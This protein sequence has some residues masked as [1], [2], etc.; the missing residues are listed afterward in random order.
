MKQVS[1]LDQIQ[2]FNILI[3]DDDEDTCNLL[4]A[5]FKTRGYVSKYVTS[6]EEAIAYVAEHDPDVVVLD[7]MM[8]NMNG[9]ETFTGIRAYSD[10][11]VLFLTAVATIDCAAHA[12]S[13]GGSDFM[14]KPF[15]HL[16]LFARIDILLKAAQ[17]KHAK[18]HKPLAHNLINRDIA[19]TVV[20]PAYNESR[21]IGS[22]VLKA[23]EYAN[24]VIVVDDGSSDNTAEIA[25]AAGAFVVKHECNK[26]KGA[27]LNTGF[28]KARELGAQVVVT[29]DAD[30]QHLPEELAQVVKPV[31]DGK[32]DIVIGSRYIQ[33]HSNVPRHR[34]LGH[35]FFNNLTKMASGVAAT[36]SQSGYRAFSAA[37][38]E[39]ISFSSKGFS[40]ESE[41]QFI[42]REKHLR[43]VEVPITI[44]YSDKPKRS[45]ISQGMQV[46]G[47]LFKIMGQYR[48]L[49]YF[50][51]TGFIL[52]LTGFIWSLFV[53]HR[54]QTTNQLALGN[55][56][57]CILTAVIGVV[58][59]STGFMLHSIRGLLADLLHSKHHN[60]G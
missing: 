25:E 58:L 33:Y 14:H 7:I 46:L 29:L 1:E 13:L 48:P 31:L 2:N 57:F 56:L 26:G 41:M 9:W 49:L 16:E 19:I 39:A 40:V 20:V 24:R 8:P 43:L 18:Q 6:G 21:F 36:D 28:G 32:A 34:I 42:A 60:P 51:L 15:S 37:A 27:A 22:T 38:L 30:G 23:L 11:P 47:G 12:L 55:A 54:Y 52:M 5:F 59:F 45:V 4:K 3:V 10:V 53:I 44:L 17:E 35:W 50:G